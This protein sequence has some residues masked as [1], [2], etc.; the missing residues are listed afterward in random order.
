MSLLAFRRCAVAAFAL[1]CAALSGCGGGFHASGTTPSSNNSPVSVQVSANASPLTS[2]CGTAVPSTDTGEMPNY[3]S[4]IQPQVAVIPA[5]AVVGVWE[6]DRWTGIGARAI[7]AAHSTD[8][9]ATWS[10]PTILAFSNCGGGSGSTYDRTSDPWISFAG[11]GIVYASALAFSANAF[12]AAGLFGNGP[13]AVLVSRSTDGGSTW[14]NPVAVWTDPNSSG[15]LYFNDRDSVTADPSSGN[16]YVVWDRLNSTGAGS[17]PAYL[18]WSKDGGVTWTSGIL[19]D[20]GGTNEA[21]NNEIAILPSGTVLDF[22]TLL[23]STGASTLQLVSLS[24]SATGWTASSPV[25]VAPIHSVG[26]PNPLSSTTVIRASSLLAQVAVDSSSGAVAAVWQQSFGSTAFDGIALS[27]STT[28]GSTWSTPIQVNGA[29]GAAAFS[30][31]VRYLPDGTLVVT[32]YDLRTYA[33]GSSRLSTSAWLTES[34]DGGKTWHELQLQS[35][36]DLNQAPVT[37]STTGFHG[38]ALF[39]GDNQGL[40]L[41][42][43]NPLPF[44]AAT[45]SA[46]GSAGAHV[47]ATRNANPLTS[48][49]A[50]TYSAAALGRLPAAVVAKARVNSERVRLRGVA[51]ME[52]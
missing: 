52:Q 26:I 50:H 23:D 46:A 12:T 16:V 20:P 28:S 27:V 29:T 2:S 14:T 17:T 19:Y 44:Y 43:N 45:T 37:D 51:L 15:T 30:P 22:F 36:F 48:S 6:Q 25:T 18:A 9:G 40:A 1:A 4:A 39:L 5:G 35:P 7:M 24:F 32:Y 31:S 42:G 21:F 3:G 33:S 49:S 13:S 10:T 47:Y 38:P 34:S 8:S 41:V 11:S